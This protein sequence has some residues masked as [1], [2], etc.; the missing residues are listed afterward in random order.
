MADTSVTSF[1]KVRFTENV[2]TRGQVDQAAF[3]FINYST[4]D[5]TVGAG[6]TLSIQLLSVP[7]D[8]A[9]EALNVKVVT[10]NGA[11]LTGTIVN[12]A[13][14][15]I[16]ASTFDLNS[17]T[18]QVKAALT[19]Y[20]AADTLSL[21]FPNSAAIKTVLEVVVSVSGFYTDWRNS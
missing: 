20:T 5:V 4:A 9:I 1:K 15:A 8:F 16:H 10:A 12:A 3:K 14:T 7:A 11:A 21:R 2:K 19:A 6:D 13:G 18:N 17:A